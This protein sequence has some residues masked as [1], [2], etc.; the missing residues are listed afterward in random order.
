MSTAA[1]DTHRWRV[2][3][4]FHPD[5]GSTPALPGIVAG[6]RY[7][8][9]FETG[10]SA[11]GLTAVDGGD[12][13]RWEHRLF[14]G[15]YD[16]AAPQDRPN[17]GGLDRYLSPYGACPRFGS[18]VL[19]L[20]PHVHPRCTFCYPDSVFEPESVV[21]PDQSEGLIRE[22]DH[23]WRAGAVDALDDY[24]EAQVHGGVRVATDVAAVILDPSFRSG[25][26]QEAAQGLG[27]PVLF[28]PGYVLREEDLRG[29]SPAYRG[30]E[31]LALIAGLAS[32]GPVTPARLAPLSRERKLH[33]Q[34]VKYA[35]HLLARFGR[36]WEDPVA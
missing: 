34:Q 13:W 3:I 26:V 2:T 36:R 35:W 6:G 14:E 18:A 28:H 9:Q 21:G 5:W 31:P 25:A 16:G 27:V 33:P 8:S 17:Y 20:A 23:A 30:S 19:V 24:I 12:R 7:L 10:T 22:A 15:R 11:G 4:N 29:V 32:G 1:G